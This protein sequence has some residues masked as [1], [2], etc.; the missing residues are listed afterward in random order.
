M[1]KTKQ[2]VLPGCDQVPL[3]FKDVPCENGYGTPLVMCKGC[4]GSGTICKGEKTIEVNASTPPKRYTRTSPAPNKSNISG[5][6]TPSHAS[7]VR[8]VAARAW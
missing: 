3:R 6:A 8:I 1:S 5:K 2:P 4:S 7:S